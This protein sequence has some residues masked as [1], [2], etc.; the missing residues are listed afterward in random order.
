[1]ARE[2]FNITLP[3]SI[4]LFPV[5]QSTSPIL[6]ATTS[7][8]G[9]DSLLSVN[10]NANKTD[11]P[12]I[13]SDQ[14]NEVLI[15]GDP[16][17]PNLPVSTAYFSYGKA[18]VPGLDEFYYSKAADVIN[19]ETPDL[20]MSGVI[21][22]INGGNANLT[23]IYPDSGGNGKI[24]LGP[25]KIWKDFN[26][27]DIVNS[28]GEVTNPGYD[29]DDGSTWAIPNVQ[30]FPQMDPADYVA[31]VQF[32]LDEGKI[33]DAAGEAFCFDWEK[34][35]L[36][37]QRLGSIFWNDT[38]NP[39][40]REALTELRNQEK[41]ICDALKA[42]FP[43]SYF[44]KYGG[45][46]DVGQFE[47]KWDGSAFVSEADTK[48]RW[49]AL[50]DQ[51]QKDIL[52]QNFKDAL[53]GTETP[54]DY[55]TKVCYDGF[56]P[57]SF[58]LHAER[59]AKDATAL[60]PPYKKVLFDWA[61]GI[62]K[63]ELNVP[64]LAVI[65]PSNIAVFDLGTNPDNSN[66]PEIPWPDGKYN[67]SDPYEW[68]TPTTWIEQTIDMIREADG[69]LIWDGLRIDQTRQFSTNYANWEDAANTPAGNVQPILNKWW[70][71]MEDLEEKYGTLTTIAN[72]FNIP[73]PTN[74]ETWFNL[75]RDTIR[76]TDF[77]RNAMSKDVIADLES[78][79]I[80]LIE[81][82]RTTRIVPYMERTAPVINGLPFAGQT[83]SLVTDFVGD[84]TAEYQW[85]QIGKVD[86]L[87]TDANYVVQE[88]DI[89]A[90][91]QCRVRFVR[92]GEQ[93]ADE[94]FVNMTG[95]I[96]NEARLEVVQSFGPAGALVRWSPGAI[97][98]MTTESVTSTLDSFFTPVGNVSIAL[99]VQPETL[100]ISDGD[101][102]SFTFPDDSTDSATWSLVGSSLGLVGGTATA[103][104]AALPV[105]SVVEAFTTSVET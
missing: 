47:L 92:D 36:T 24:S 68:A 84:A 81:E 28:E 83:L 86:V 1:M 93:I 63:S 67:S 104:I 25:D 23:M 34:N 52:A 18:P 62:M 39:K 97:Q 72:E 82:W 65:S 50:L 74:A 7:G 19:G 35:T 13:H 101:T 22:L 48:I 15:V 10:V 69:Y 5:T 44:G 4:P 89:G 30:R 46:V 76:R 21:N 12:E 27:L 98:L 2:D 96:T 6:P 43:D 57:D 85:Q 26:L 20:D 70:N 94:V 33:A 91:I 105:G 49:F 38:S 29:P 58:R 73:V 75:D 42:A 16:P 8:L 80:P 11:T 61:F 59:P 100:L 60:K 31:A 90:N 79:L 40:F 71:L 77:F 17:A 99:P 103:T 88:S 54:W 3:Q 53:A 78:T 14:S 32:F 95:P 51:S 56:A 87:S 45:T 66:P 37:V 55:V 64:C 41:V 9:I 102:I